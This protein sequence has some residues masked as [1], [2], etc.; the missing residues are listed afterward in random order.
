VA[1][2]K[3]G[4]HPAD[5][6]R[7]NFE[8]DEA[9]CKSLATS[10]GAAG[11]FLLPQAVS[12]E[13]IEL[14]R[15]K[16]VV[17]AASPRIVTIDDSMDF[18]KLTGGATAYWIGEDQSITT[19]QQTIGQVRAELKTVAALTPVTNKL[20]NAKSAT[21]SAEQMIRDDFVKCIATAQDAAFLRG[22]GTA[23]SPKGMV[24]W[25]AAVAGNMTSPTSFTTKIA[26][27][28][29]LISAL[30]NANVSID[31][32]E[33]AFFGPPRTE[34]ALM[35]EVSSTGVRIFAEELRTGRLEGY[36]AFFSTNLPITLTPGTASE[37]IF[38]NMTDM[39]VA[40]GESIR[41]DLSDV[42]TWV[43]GGTTYSCFQNNV[44]LIRV[45]QD[46]DFIV[47]HTESVAYMNDVTWS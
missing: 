16:S 7:K 44:S 38:A 26:D 25:P 27:L 30:G 10:T 22:S 29:T 11:G 47:R 3:Q 5:Y 32:N 23:Y 13:I 12:A 33:C 6:A 41:I 42:A 31:K 1:Q 9:L 21:V 2:K 19:S 45:L 43:S 20:L 15:A 40:E 18:T 46:V 28:W 24:N 36:R 35:K 4:I 14:L 34:A 17:R 37:L 39:I 8:R